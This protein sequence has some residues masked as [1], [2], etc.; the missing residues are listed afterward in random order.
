MN[1]LEWKR[2]CG[3]AWRATHSHS[4]S[5]SQ[6]LLY[7]SFG[8]SPWAVSPA[9][10][11]AQMQYLSEHFDVVPLAQLLTQAHGG[12]TRCAITFDDGY[13]SVFQIALPI[14][15]QVGFPATLYL[16][17][18]AIAE[19][20][21]LSSGDFPGLY[22]GDRMLNW[23]QAMAL[24]DG[25]VSIGS[26]LMEHRAVTELAPQQA[27]VQLAGS[28]QKIEQRLGTP[29]EDFSYPWGRYHRASL[30][31]VQAAGYHTAVTGL[32]YP[33]KSGGDPLLIPRMDIRRE[34]SLEDFAA[35]LCGDWD[36]LGWWQSILRMARA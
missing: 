14:L 29:C 33:W 7:H 26:H 9:D 34:Y 24:A 1:R 20:D 19:R 6:V 5:R 32:H 25:G 12:R 18:D 13:E 21:N 15:R 10:F 2:R 11:A 31:W 28:K 17:T 8:A 30:D 3:R 27:S 36:Y 35:I 22:P 23:T 4:A 16:T